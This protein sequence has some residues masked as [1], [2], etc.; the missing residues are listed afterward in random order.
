[1]TLKSLSSLLKHFKRVFIGQVA[2]MWSSRIP[3]SEC[4][5]LHLNDL[6]ENKTITFLI[7]RSELH[8]V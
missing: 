8:K 1:M 4:I 5:K 3:L 7:F 6:S 2:S